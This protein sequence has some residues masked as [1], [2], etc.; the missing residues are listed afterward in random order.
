MAKTQFRPALSV[1][2]LMLT[3]SLLST[4]LS[5]FVVPVCE[6]LGFGRG[7]FTL[8]YS[9]LVAAGAF[10]NMKG[11]PMDGTSKKDALRSHR[12]YLAVALMCILAIGS[13][14]SQHLPSVLGEM[15]HD[16]AHIG[17]MVSVM[18]AASAVGTVAEGAICGKLGIKKTMLGVL[19]VYAVGF[20]FMGLRVNVYTALAFLAFGSGSIG[21]LMPIVVRRIFGGRDYAAIWSVVISCSSVASFIGAPVWGMVYD[22]SGSYR[23]ALMAM[24][25]VLAAGIACLFGAFR[26]IED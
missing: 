17:L 20:V 16:S 9:L 5:F 6:D 18:T 21:T 10:G 12:F 24:P 23:P 19:I 4:A 25:V 15:G 8:Y 3:M 22:F 11:I 14:V 26:N 1:F 7:S 2:L 13:C